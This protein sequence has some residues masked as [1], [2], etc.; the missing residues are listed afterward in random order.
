MCLRQRPRVPTQES[1]LLRGVIVILTKISV[2]L[3][4]LLFRKTLAEKRVL[5]ETRDNDTCMT[6]IRTQRSRFLLYFTQTVGFKTRVDWLDHGWISNPNNRKK[7]KTKKRERERTASLSW[8]YWVK[9]LET[10][11]T[12]LVCAL[13]FDFLCMDLFFFLW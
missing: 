6:L 7:P 10:N 12:V 4:T 13:C 3:S 2:F 8:A 1:Y 11:T 5:F 9:T